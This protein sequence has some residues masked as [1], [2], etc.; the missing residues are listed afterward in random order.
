MKNPLITLLVCLMLGIS[1]TLAA[2]NPKAQK[3]YLPKC[4]KK[5]KIYLGMSESDFLAQCP[6]CALDESNSFS[7]FRS[8]Y[9]SPLND[10]VFEEAIFYVSTDNKDF[11]EMILI[12]KESENATDYAHKLLGEP[13][14]DED[15]WRYSPK[16]T[17]EAFT[18]AA[19]NYKNKFIVAGSVKGSE[20]EEG[21][22]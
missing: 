10:N 18:I 9:I 3:N 8:V 4:I 1:S 6:Q 22:N 20:W 11:Y 19:W 15:E 2:Q 12:A 21:F 5:M 17:G 16:V 13:N 14:A 7:S